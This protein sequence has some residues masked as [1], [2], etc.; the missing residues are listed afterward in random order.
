MI[1]KFN[2]AESEEQHDFF[3]KVATSGKL[4]IAAING[5]APG[6]GFELALLVII[7]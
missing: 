5:F 2:K 3:N 4:A 7:E 1:L 6:G